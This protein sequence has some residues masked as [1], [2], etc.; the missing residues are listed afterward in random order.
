MPSPIVF[1]DLAGEDAEALKSF[2]AALFDWNA[3]AQGQFAVPAVAP[4]MGAIRSDPAE[5]RIY[6]GVQD[7]EATLKEVEARGGSVDVPRFE[8]P[9]VVVLGLFRDPAGNPMGL[10]EMDGDEHKVP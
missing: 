10:V 9:G 2:Y 7:I 6:V 3:D 4:L 1:F 8:V 5:K